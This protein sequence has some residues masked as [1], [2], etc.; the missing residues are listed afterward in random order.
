MN[1]KKLKILIVDDNPDLRRLL[2][3][4]FKVFANCE[5]LNAKNGSEALN[6]IRNERPHIMF[7]DIM[8]PGEIDGFGV[9]EFVKSSTFKTCFVVMLTAKSTY[10]DEQYAL[11]LGADKYITKP[12]SPITLIEIV[13]NWRDTHFDLKIESPT[14]LVID[15]QESIRRMITLSLKDNY[16][17]ISAENGIDALLILEEND[18]VDLVIVDIMMQEKDGIETITDISKMKTKMP[19]IAMTG[20]LFPMYSDLHSTTANLLGVKAIL[21]KPFNLEA[22]RSTVKA[23]MTSTSD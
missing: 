22:L 18:A 12:F 9:C 14:V 8:M 5:I 17:V 20:N 15:E 19:I 23:V 13:E 4:T 3:T 2:N 16:Q 1:N 21:G 11:T 7:L 10:I 6:I